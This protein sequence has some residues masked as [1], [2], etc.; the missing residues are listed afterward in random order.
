MWTEYC[1]ERKLPILKCG[2]LVV[3]K[4]EEELPAMKNLYEQGLKNKVELN[5]ISASEARKIDPFV[6]GY[7]NEFIWSPT[8][9]V[10]DSKALVQ[11]MANDII[12]RN[13]GAQVSL[14]TNKQYVK[15]EVS[16]DQNKLTRVLTGDG[17]VIECK[18]FINAAGQQ[19]LDIAHEHGV[20]TEFDFFPMK[21]LYAISERPLDHLYKT[22]VYPVPIAGAYFLGVHSTLTIDGHVKIGPTV[23]PAFGVE[24]YHGL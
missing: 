13:T 2:K 6:K 7:G 1:E 5:M 14:L 10:V 24:N 18:Y 16:R 8:T 4:S 19:S 15:S 9:A 17:E 23:A 22:L 21:G 11:G 20:G 3:P 12:T